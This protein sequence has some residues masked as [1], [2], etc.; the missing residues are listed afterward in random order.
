MASDQD[1]PAVAPRPDYFHLFVDYAGLGAM[2]VV[3]LVCWLALHLKGAELVLAATWGLVAG[4]AVAVGASLIVRRKIATMPA[5]YGATAL[6][7][8]GLTLFYRDPQ[9]VEMK[10]TFIDTGLG[11]LM[12]GGLAMGRSPIRLLMGQAIHLSDRGWKTLTLRFG[13]FFLAMALTNEIVRHQS[14]EL[15]LSFRVLGSVVLTLIFSALQA[16]LLLREA[17]PAA[18]PPADDPRS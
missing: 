10:T 8:G 12:L 1:S 14:H 18:E 7:F 5:I 16:P 2:L 4:S 3:S 6:V 17:H 13:V 11:V 9:I 15:W